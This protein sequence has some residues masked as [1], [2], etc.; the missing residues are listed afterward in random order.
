MDV[1]SVIQVSVSLLSISVIVHGLRANALLQ[2]Q[3]QTQLF[4]LPEHYHAYVV[5][6]SRRHSL[7]TN[8]K[9]VQLTNTDAIF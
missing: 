5:E 9:T 6:K 4:L 2:S 3:R 8:K 7:Y 1:L